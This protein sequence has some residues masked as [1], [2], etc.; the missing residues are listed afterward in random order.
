MVA[1]TN[2]T[3][4]LVA[5]ALSILANSAIL[6]RPGAPAASDTRSIPIAIDYKVCQQRHNHKPCIAQRPGY[7]GHGQ[8][9]THRDYRAEDKD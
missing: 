8:I 6:G 3:I 5:A 1:T 4:K 9:Q 2:S 7:L